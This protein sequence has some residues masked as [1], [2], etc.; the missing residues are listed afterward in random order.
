MNHHS[1]LICRISLILI[2][3][4]IS[5]CSTAPTETFLNSPIHLIYGNM[6]NMEN[7]FGDKVTVKDMISYGVNPKAEKK[8]KKVEDGTWSLLLDLKDNVTGKTSNFNIVL[9]Q[10]NSPNRVIFHRIIVD[11]QEA[12]IR[13]KDT[14]ANQFILTA[15][16]VKEGK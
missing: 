3:G 16:Q 1:R 9:I 2:L 6:P 8:W 13:E 15:Y 10:Q 12:N 7:N 4:F 5:A 11:G 14:L